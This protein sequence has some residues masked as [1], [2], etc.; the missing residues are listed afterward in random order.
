ML[1]RRGTGEAA[2]RRGVHACAHSGLQRLHHV[3]VEI[4]NRNALHAGC[5]RKWGRQFDLILEGGSFSE[6]RLLAAKLCTNK[7]T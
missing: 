6:D 2:H 4:R 7:H 5:V 1:L 3:H